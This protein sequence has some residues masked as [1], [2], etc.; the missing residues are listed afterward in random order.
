MKN[1]KPKNVVKQNPSILKQIKKVAKKVNLAGGIDQL[2]K[3][4]PKMLSAAGKV[5]HSLSALLR[6][7]VPVEIKDDT[8]KLAVHFKFHQDQILAEKRYQK[9]REIIKKVIGKDYKIDCVLASE[10]DEKIIESIKDKMAKMDRKTEENL[11]K[12]VSEVFGI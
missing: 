1:L 10:V 2:V 11:M 5:N 7:S 4:W 8:I 9:I 3:A 6:S 12:S